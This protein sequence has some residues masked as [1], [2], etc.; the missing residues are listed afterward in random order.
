[1]PADATTTPNGGILRGCQYPL[2]VASFSL[3]C[4]RLAPQAKKIFGTCLRRDTAGLS[5]PFGSCVVLAS[6]PQA[7]AAGK[8]FFLERCGILRG[9][10]DRL[11]RRDTKPGAPL[12]RPPLGR[13][14]I[15]PLKNEKAIIDASPSGTL[16]GPKLPDE[17]D[18]GH[19]PRTPLCSACLCCSN[20][21]QKEKARCLKSDVGKL[22]MS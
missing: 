6:L 9:C 20:H 11:A 10:Q 8:K 16:S 18:A 14:K 19:V 4:R 22:F 12:S 7:R 1:V 13:P 17:D 5:A 2:G 21:T 15:E 3:A